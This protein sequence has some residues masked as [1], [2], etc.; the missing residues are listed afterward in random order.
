MLEVM[1]KQK[2]HLE[3]QTAL[4]KAAAAAAE[5]SFH[6]LA[7]Q[8]LEDFDQELAELKANH[9]A[10]MAQLRR[11]LDEKDAL[12]RQWDKVP[13]RVSPKWLDAASWALLAL[14]VLFA[15]IQ[16]CQC[17]WASVVAKDHVV[18][19]RYVTSARVTNST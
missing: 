18:M 16:A 15:T 10:A 6:Q 3:Q 1:T 17:L 14:A 7:Q 8:Q 2:L 12:L 9:D 11:Q 4:L 19:R 5:H 13:I